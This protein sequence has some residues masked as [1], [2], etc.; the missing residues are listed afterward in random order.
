MFAFWR[1]PERLSEENYLSLPIQEVSKGR[2]IDIKKMLLQ[3]HRKENE[4]AS[5]ELLEQKEDIPGKNEQLIEWESL[6]KTAKISLTQEWFSKLHS[7]ESKHA[8]FRS[9]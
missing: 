3:K 6:D 7:W 8:Q 5:S 1:F 2:E 9:C 4:K